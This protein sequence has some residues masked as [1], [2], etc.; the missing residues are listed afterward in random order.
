[1]ATGDVSIESNV[2]FVIFAVRLGRFGKIFDIGPIFSV[3]SGPGFQPG[4][5]SSGLLGFGAF[6]LVIEAEVSEATLAVLAF[7]EV[8]KGD[9]FAVAKDQPNGNF[10]EGEFL[11]KAIHEVAFVTTF[12]ELLA[13][14]DEDDGGRVDGDLADIEDFG[15]ATEL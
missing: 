11:T 5:R 4:E 15:L 6:V 8:L 13:I 9:A 3:E 14:H 2:D 1:M 12:E 7:F 10:T